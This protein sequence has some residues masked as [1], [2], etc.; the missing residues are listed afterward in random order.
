MFDIQKFETLLNVN[1]A[2]KDPSIP[3]PEYPRPQFVR[4]YWQ[5]LNGSWSFEFDEG[6]I[7]LKEHWEMAH[8]FSKRII[9]MYGINVNST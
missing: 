4:P 1:V 8:T 7:G 9:V 5:N 2:P 6:N 3:R